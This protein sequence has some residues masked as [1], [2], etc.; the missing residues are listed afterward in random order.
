MV[1]KSIQ[2]WCNRCY[3]EGTKRKQDSYYY[4]QGYDFGIDLFCKQEE[5]TLHGI[6]IRIFRSRIMNRFII[7]DTPSKID[8]SM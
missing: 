5:W 4:K 2:R 6:Y 3:V 1:Y 8:I 7:E